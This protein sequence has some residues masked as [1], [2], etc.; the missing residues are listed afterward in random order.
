[1]KHLNLLKI[2]ALTLAL[3][4]ASVSAFAGTPLSG[5]GTASATLLKPG[6]IVETTKLNF[7]SF[8]ANTGSTTSSITISADASANATYTGASAIGDVSPTVAKFAVT[9]NATINTTPSITLPST[10]TLNKQNG[11]G[12]YMTIGN[13]NASRLPANMEA[14]KVYLLYV[15]GTLSFNGVNQ[16]PG[17]YEGSYTVSVNY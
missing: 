11:N 8:M 10:V 14:N 4:S 2:T 3:S 7:G 16:V 13:L 12:E 5:T 9:P 17:V 6:S 15:G 1:M